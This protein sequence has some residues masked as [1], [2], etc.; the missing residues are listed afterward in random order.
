MVK[1]AQEDCEQHVDACCNTVI[2]AVL[3]I[4]VDIEHAETHNPHTCEKT[5]QCDDHQP[6]S[7]GFDALHALA[8]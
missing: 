3:N 5:K 7:K 8:A 2:S 1:V 6:P 4:A